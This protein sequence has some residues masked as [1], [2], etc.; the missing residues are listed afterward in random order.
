MPADLEGLLRRLQTSFRDETAQVVPVF[1]QLRRSVE[2]LAQHADDLERSTRGYPVLR[3]YADALTVSVA[4]AQ[5]GLIR[6]DGAIDGLGT[7]LTAGLRDFRAGIGWIGTAVTQELAI[8]ELLWVARGAAGTVANSMQRFADP[9][10]LFQPGPRSGSDLFGELGLMFRTM[11]VPSGGTTG[12]QEILGAAATFEGVTG[13]KLSETPFD[14]AQFA[15]TLDDLGWELFGVM[16]ALPLVPAVRTV[17]EA[18]VTLAERMLTDELQ[19]AEAALGPLRQGVADVMRAV[20][21][22][23]QTA[24][25]FLTTFGW[26]IESVV[27][28]SLALAEHYVARVFDDLRRWASGLSDML[29]G[30]RKVAEGIRSVLALLLNTD[31]MPFLLGPLYDLL[32]SAIT[33]HLTLDNLVDVGVDVALGQARGAVT[34]AADALRIVLPLS[35]QPRVDA[36]EKAALILL[37]PSAPLV[38]TGLPPPTPPFPEVAAAF[39]HRPETAAMAASLARLGHDLP[40][41]VHTVLDAGATAS[42]S[43]AAS[44]REAAGRA[45][46]FPRDELAGVAGEAQAQAALVRG[47]L[48]PGPPV[49]ADLQKVARSFEQQLARGGIM[50]AAAAI[51]VLAAQLRRRW[52]QRAA[53]AAPDRGA[54]RTGPRPPLPTSP[55]HLATRARVTTVTTPRILIRLPVHELDDALIGEAVEALE[56]GALEAWETGNRRGARE[57][58]GVGHGR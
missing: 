36:F 32:P 43:V 56:S 15:A 17:V 22:A 2:R 52:Q 21:T 31:L 11:V 27:A 28:L 14:P 16:A 51:P 33:P 48:Q 45:A 25:T 4:P 1:D 30:W 34:A 3:F 10:S 41:R 12:A 42:A 54:H 49:D 53:P 26:V 47:V 39:L 7:A 55:H 24:E 29:E 18:G 38:E 6:L 20:L 35:A 5:H 23:A 9:A 37:T 19:R 58:V 44:F 40:V 8:P 57:P 46:T 50:L 13:F